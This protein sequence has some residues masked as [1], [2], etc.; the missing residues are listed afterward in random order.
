MVI[1]LNEFEKIKKLANK[2]C[3]FPEPVEINRVDDNVVYN[4]KSI[5]SLFAMDL[6]SPLNV[7]IVTNDPER[8]AIFEREMSEFTEE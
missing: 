4:C 2:V 6:S 5:L 1:K 3:A 8:V 7:R